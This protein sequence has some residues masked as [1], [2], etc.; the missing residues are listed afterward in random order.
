M[1]LLVQDIGVLVFMFV[2]SVSYSS[3]AA[4]FPA[5]Y[6]GLQLSKSPEGAKTILPNPARAYSCIKSSTGQSL[7]RSRRSRR[8]SLPCGL[9]FSLSPDEIA[10]GGEWSPMRFAATRRLWVIDSR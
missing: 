2:A 4:T 9:A 1:G 10:R 8:A 6:Q 5:Q 7:D 3:K